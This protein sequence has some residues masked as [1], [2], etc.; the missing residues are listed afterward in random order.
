MPEVWGGAQGVA[1]ADRDLQDHLQDKERAKER[2]RQDPSETKDRDFQ[3]KQA[4]C[5]RCYCLA[6]S[7]GCPPD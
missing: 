5:N 7:K 3:Y 6:N 4:E 2:L 1:E